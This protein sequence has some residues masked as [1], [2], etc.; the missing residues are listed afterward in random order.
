MFLTPKDHNE[1][2]SKNLN[3]IVSDGV[4]GWDHRNRA[5]SSELD[6]IRMKE[7]K[8]ILENSKKFPEVIST[9]GRY[10]E[11]VPEVYKNFHGRWKGEPPFTSVGTSWTGTRNF[12]EFS[13]NFLVGVND[14]IF[15][16]GLN[17]YKYMVPI[18][19]SEMPTEEFMKELVGLPNDLYAS[20]HLYVQAKFVIQ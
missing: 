16:W 2:E 19:I 6:E 1:L 17:K 4:N 11:L 20:D 7:V 13:F 10:E 14:Y 18:E 12:S 8:E 5:I 15:A 3:K 9:Y